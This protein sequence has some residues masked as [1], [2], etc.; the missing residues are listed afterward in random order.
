MKIE[1]KK[2]TEMI[3]FYQNTKIYFNK[4]IDKKTFNTLKKKLVSPFFN[5]RFS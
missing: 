2:I 1:I 3:K 4:D 5:G